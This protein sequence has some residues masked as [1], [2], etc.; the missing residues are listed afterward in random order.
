[1][2]NLRLLL[3]IFFLLPGLFIYGQGGWYDVGSPG[4]AGGETYSPSLGYHSSYGYTV[5]YRDMAYAGYGSVQNYY[6]GSWGYMGSPGFTPGTV[7]YTGLAYNQSTGTPYFGYSDGAYGGYASAMYYGGSAW[8]QYGGPGYSAGYAGYTGIAVDGSGNVYSTYMDGAYGDRGTVMTHGATGW[9]P[10]GP[11]GFTPGYAGSI[12]LAVNG[13][14]PIVAYADG[15]QGG[16]LSVMQ[17][18]G[19][20]WSNLGTAGFSASPVSYISVALDNS[21]V[22]L[23]AFSDGAHSDHLSVMKYDGVGSWSYLGSPGFSDGFAGYPSV[24]VCPVSGTPYV[25]YRDFTF[26]GLH[27]KKYDGTGWTCVGTNPVSPNPGDYLSL[28]VTPSGTPAVAYCDETINYDI[29][30]REY[31][32]PFTPGTIQ[33]SQ[34]I[35]YGDIP[36]LLTATEPTGGIPPYTYQWKSSP[37]GTTWTNIAGATSLTY[38]PPAL[39]ATTHYEQDQFETGGFGTVTTNSLEITVI[40]PPS[41]DAGPNQTIC[42]GDVVNL[43]GTADNTSGVLWTT[44]GD[45]NFGSATSLVTTYTPGP[46]D[47]VAGS[48]SLTLTGYPISPCTQEAQDGLVVTIQLNPTVDAGPSDWTCEFDPFILSGTATNHSSVMWTTS[49]DGTFDDPTKLNAVYT[50]GPN[51]VANG[52]VTLTLKAYPISPC[53]D[54]VT[55][56][57]TL[58]IELEPTAYAGPD[59]TICENQIAS[60]LG[61]ATNWDHVAWTTSGDGAFTAPANPV[62]DYLPGPLDILTGTVTLF[63]E[64]F[65]PLGVCPSAIDNLV[66]TIELLPY[67]DPGPNA[68]ICEGSTYLLAAATAQNYASLFWGTTGDGSY[69]D[70]TILNPV[71]T[72]GPLDIVNGTVDLSLTAEAIV[73]CSPDDTEW[74]T[75]TIQ[76]MATAFAGG[77]GATCEYNPYYC[78]G[79]ATGFTAINWSTSGD[80][81]F[82]DPTLQDPTYT[83]GPGDVNAGSVDLTMGVTP[84]LP[85]TTMVSDV[86]TLDIDSNPTADAGPD[87]AICQG[88]PYPL[89]GASATDYSAIVWAT[90]GDGYFND[91]T[92]VNP[93][94]YPGAGDIAAGSVVLTITAHPDGVCTTPAS[95]NMTLTIYPSAL[96]MAGPDG[97]TCPEVPYQLNGSSMYASYTYWNTIGGDG[98]FDDPFKPDAVYTPGPMDTT[99][100]SVHLVLIAYPLPPCTGEGQDTTLLTMEPAPTVHA[101]EDHVVIPGASIQL[102]G[103]ATGGTGKHD[104]HWTPENMVQDP[105][106]PNTVT[107]PI[108]DTTQFTLEAT[109]QNSGCSRTDNVTMTVE[110]PGTVYEISGNVHTEKPVV[111]MPGVTVSFSNIGLDVITDTNGNYVATVPSGYVGE[112][113]PTHASHV[114]V[115]D[116]N[117]YKYV[118]EN[119]TG[120][121]FVG[122]VFLT[123]TADPDTICAGTPQTSQLNAEVVKPVGG[124]NFE[125]YDPDGLISTVQDPVVQPEVTT[126]YTVIAT[127]EIHRSWDTITV[128]VDECTFIPEFGNVIWVN[129]YPIPTSGKLWIDIRNITDD[130]KVSILNVYG[131]P[132]YEE[133][134]SGEYFQHRISYSTATIPVGVYYVTIVDM[135]GVVLHV[136]KVV[137][138]RR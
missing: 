76:E 112:A 42:E 27:V 59:Q 111:P 34:T 55:D 52:S 118:D 92:L 61:V 48:V 21:G 85:C 105:T 66:L 130:L 89:N 103:S 113:V 108:E 121:D 83:P 41:V 95:D 94:Y 104:F 134:V 45:G 13:S 81:T 16:R 33:P 109:D 65:S 129:I 15:S 110:P 39:T 116:T 68:T 20:S 125:W 131:R 122:S 126:Q 100:G 1:M 8:Y 7:E 127:D 40:Q 102:E 86:A 71:Y 132:I 84:T 46:L 38:Q 19:G 24:A 31:L 106:N 123:A 4:I 35:C 91:A 3:L 82:D 54:P 14:G 58:N 93:I 49:G 53:V 137:K 9:G 11:P 50:P 18:Q 2:K 32:D 44:S 43:N 107:M 28:T 72:P 57:M 60:L 97:F 98:T 99:N 114:F 101:G 135:D 117:F 79:V 120:Q 47:I 5:G 26:T 78:P 30:V 17:Y 96:A 88:Q 6:G 67:A 23:V 138:V 75:L 119:K 73:P 25:A 22:P 87:D 37:N 115:P 56:N 77:N 90:S 136:R 36:G 124:V 62:T 51:D 128:Y 69:N 10:V 74:M 29:V 70:P 133:K 64:A 12:G 63:F 80:G